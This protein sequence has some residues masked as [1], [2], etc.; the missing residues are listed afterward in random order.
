MTSESQD[1]SS[2]VDFVMNFQTALSWKSK[3]HISMKFDDGVHHMLVSHLAVTLHRSKSQRFTWQINHAYSKHSRQLCRICRDATI[4]VCTLSVSCT[5]LK[6]KQLFF[7]LSWLH[8]YISKCT[9]DTKNKRTEPI[10]FI[11]S[12]LL[13]H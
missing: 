13:Y 12:L 8:Y 7:K 10:M 9:S 5:E 11:E 6:S 3:Q 1:D 2:L 4:L